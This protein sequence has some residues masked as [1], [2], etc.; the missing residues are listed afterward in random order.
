MPQQWEHLTFEIRYDKR[1][2]AWVA[3]PPGPESAEGVSDIL[4]ACGREGWELAAFQVERQQLHA[5]ILGSWYMEPE[6]YRATFK[7]TRG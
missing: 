1:R 7:R 6:A 4:D 2:K 5:G 3:A